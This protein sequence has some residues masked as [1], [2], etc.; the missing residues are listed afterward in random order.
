MTERRQG[1]YRAMVCEAVGAPL[2]MRERAEPSL[3]QP[4]DVVIEVCACGVCRTDLHVVDGELARRAQTIVPGHEVVGRV[5]EAGP[6]I[7][8]LKPGARVGAAWLA[9]ACGACVYCRAAREN[10]CPNAEFHGWTR[11]GGYAERMVADGRFLFA[12]P[13]G[14]PDAAIAP[15]LCA[16]LIG[17]RSLTMT[18]DAQ[19]VGLYGFGAAAHIVAQVALWQG[20]RV[21]A[22]VRPGDAGATALALEI[23]CHSAQGS[24]ASAPEEL[25]AAILFAPA[26]ALVPIALR[27]VRPGGIVV[28]AGIHMSDIPSFPYEILWGER[29]LRSVANLTRKDGEE[30]LA[31]AP[32]AGV[33]ATI[34]TF[35]FEDAN[36]A[37]QRLRAGAIN[38]A[39][40]L[41]MT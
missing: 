9:F 41:T 11:D 19:R 40:V 10:L 32:K 12:L 14:P 2:V 13:D 27:A 16:G 24:D 17:Y 34:Q 1:Q 7:E 37:L 28:C 4:T 5:I 22:F 6:A 25:D 21:H 15:L 30:F 29:V 8:T 26:G 35:A 3:R 20:R 38:G 23:G 39:A 36:L 31:L 33:R 18:G